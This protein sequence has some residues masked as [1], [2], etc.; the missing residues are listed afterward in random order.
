[1]PLLKCLRSSSLK[2][3]KTSVEK[4]FEISLAKE[5]AKWKLE[6]EKLENEIL[7]LNEDAQQSTLLRSRCTARANKAPDVDE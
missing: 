7:D 3:D 2:T 5:K 6:R 4:D 1:M